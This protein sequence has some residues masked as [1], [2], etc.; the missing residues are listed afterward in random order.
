MN[1]VVTV[2]ATLALVAGFATAAAPGWRPSIPRLP[3]ARHRGGGRQLRD[4]LA[5]VP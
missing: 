3:P 2:L 4:H 5:R 1:A